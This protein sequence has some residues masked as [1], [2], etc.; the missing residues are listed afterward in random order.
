MEEIQSFFAARI[1]LPGF[2]PDDGWSE[3]LATTI[4]EN[5]LNDEDAKTMYVYADP[6]TGTAGSGGL[7][8]G[9]SC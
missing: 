8:I 1:Q 3:E 2:H 4:D 7:R 5:Y 6:A 9:R